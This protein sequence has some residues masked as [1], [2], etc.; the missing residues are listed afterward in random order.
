[1]NILVQISPDEIL[2]AFQII[3]SMD[4]ILCVIDIFSS[5]FCSPLF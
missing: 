4:N 5:F 3:V 2:K 1:M